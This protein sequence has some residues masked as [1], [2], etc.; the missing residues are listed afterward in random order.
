M[1]RG[2]RA[3]AHVA[4]SDPTAIAKAVAELP[5]G[6]DELAL[7]LVA[8]QGAPDAAALV[9]HLNRTERT[10]LGG[11]FPAVVV[12]GERHDRG[13]LILGLPMLVEP[14][15][16]PELHRPQSFALPA[17]LAAPAAHKPT[18]VV[19]VD[20]LTAGISPFLQAVYHQLGNQVSY[21]GGGAG[22]LG[23]ARSPCLFT[24]EGAFQGAAA[25]ALT[26]LPS[27]IGVRHGWRELKGPY[28]VTRSRRNVIVEL[29]WK[30]AL[31]LYQ[32]AVEQD[33]GTPLSIERL[34]QV[35]PAYPFGLRKEGH[36][37]VVRDPI[38]PGEGGTLVCVGDVPENAVL[39]ILKGDPE[40]LVAAAGCAADDAC[41]ERP[42]AFR[43]CLLADCISRAVY[44]GQ[45]FPEELAAI[46]TALRRG[47]GAPDSAPDGMLTLGEISSAG[48][49]T[50]E[51]F[52]KTSVVAVVHDH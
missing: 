4:S 22:S 21:W 48:L 3:R 35:S 34:F 16:V 44:L 15:V 30:S 33:V 9:R 25:I 39:S 49:G 26:A 10:F 43:H 2:V 27:R 17:A 52:N 11:L 14:V 28:V 36:E 19:L 38:A 45:R 1:D 13:A 32:A 20:G 8:E 18:A 29:N 42:P 46:R 23:L 51:F 37:V 6:R 5:G 40:G 12:A 47:L 50:L 24:R 31:T 7:V 41:A